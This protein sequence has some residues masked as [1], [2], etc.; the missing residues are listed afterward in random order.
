MQLCCSLKDMLAERLVGIY[1]H[2]SLAM[3]CFNPLRSDV[4]LLAVLSEPLAAQLAVRLTRLLLDLSL[5]PHPIEISFVT[6]EQLTPWRFPTPYDFHYSEAWRDRMI[7]HL[8][9]GGEWLPT[10]SSPTDP[11]LAAHFTILRHRGI[12][13][14][15]PSTES[16]F[17]TVPAQDYLSAIWQYDT[18]DCAVWIETNPVYGV[19]NLCRV[20]SYVTEGLIVSKDEGGEWALRAV[21][22]NQRGVVELALALYRGEITDDT[23]QA[24]F[25]PGMLHAFAQHMTAGIT[26]RIERPNS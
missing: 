1:L 15:G 10:D 19:L 7:S 8:A 6:L 18:F 26:E 11:D 4:D 14:S 24:C 16:V 9:A 12:V 22:Q 13:L 2:G 20:L 25:D 3:G 23:N 5:Y 17:P 21:S